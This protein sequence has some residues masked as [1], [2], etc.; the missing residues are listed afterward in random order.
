MVCLAAASPS[1]GGRASPVTL[2]DRRVVPQ[3]SGLAPAPPILR[4]NNAPPPRDDNHV[5]Y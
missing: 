4:S 1:A 2:A 5:D 3:H